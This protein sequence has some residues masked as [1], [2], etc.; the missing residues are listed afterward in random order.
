MVPWRLI[1]VNPCR[2]RPHT[3]T[4]ISQTRLLY[5]ISGQYIFH[6]PSTAHPSLRPW[7]SAVQWWRL[8]HEQRYLWEAPWSACQQNVE[9]Q[10]NSYTEYKIFAQTVCACTATE[11]CI[12]FW[13]F[14][15]TVWVCYQTESQ[16]RWLI[17]FDWSRG[18]TYTWDVFN[19]ATREIKHEIPFATSSNLHTR[20][21]VGLL[22][23]VHKRVT[24]LLVKT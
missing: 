18:Q 5:S 19:L 1:L 14:R 22:Q 23:A 17:W 10:I 16:M 7:C 20:W 12:G 15:L 4:H 6:Q 3:H 24:W 13:S 9:I 21:V 11:N 8:E 2:H